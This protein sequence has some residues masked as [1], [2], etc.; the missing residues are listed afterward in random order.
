MVPDYSNIK[1][2]MND[3]QRFFKDQGVD[4]SAKDSKT[5]ASIFKECDT[6]DEKGE[7]K[8][9]GVLTGAERDKFFDKI[10]SACPKLVNSVV[11]FFVTVEII[12]EQK[13]LKRVKQMI[14]EQKAQESKNIDKET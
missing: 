3:I 7:K 14:E 5:L 2:N 1:F 9:D 13:E 12:E 10:K 4:V 6:Q 8:A 11:D